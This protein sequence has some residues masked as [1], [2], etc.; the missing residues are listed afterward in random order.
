MRCEPPRGRIGILRVA[1]GGALGTVGGGLTG[2]QLQH[3]ES[4]QAEQQRQ[5]KEQQREIA[6]QRREREH[7]QQQEEE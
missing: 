7:L 1:I 4:T 5:I 2:D 3:Q 6:H